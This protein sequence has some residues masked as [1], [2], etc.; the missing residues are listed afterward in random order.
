M[1]TIPTLAELR[2]QIK[3]DW[4]S[5]LQI[6]IPVFGKAVLWAIT[7]VQAAKLK[8][9]YLAIGLTQKNIDDLN[10]NTSQIG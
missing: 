6:T 10:N 9:I 4:E 8:L 5:N 1:I 3:S 7:L 2:T